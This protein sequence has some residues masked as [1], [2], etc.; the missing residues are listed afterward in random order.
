MTE[1]RKAYTRFDTVIQIQTSLP[2]GLASPSTWTGLGS[3][4]VK[5]MPVVEL[6]LILL[7]PIVWYVTPNLIDMIEKRN[8]L[9]TEINLLT[10]VED[11]NLRKLW[12]GLASS[13]SIISLSMIIYSEE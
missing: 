6:Y 13:L 11:K 9:E 10:L 3:Y 5:L 2:V 4:L 12:A 1:R 7:L 8:Y